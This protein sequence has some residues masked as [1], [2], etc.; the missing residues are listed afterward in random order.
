MITVIIEIKVPP[1]ETRESIVE[2][3][4]ETAG[5]FRTIPG[6]IRKYYCVSADNDRVTT[7]NLWEAQEAVDAYH[8]PDWYTKLKERWGEPDRWMI[9]DTPIVVDNLNETTTTSP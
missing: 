6:L 8:T 4:T 9:Y 5:T 2:K 1:G 3:Y 7:V